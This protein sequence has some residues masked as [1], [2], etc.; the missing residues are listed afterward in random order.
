MVQGPTP[1]HEGLAPA[2]LIYYLL[3]REKMPIPGTHI[4][5]ARML[6]IGRTMHILGL[7]QKRDH[8]PQNVDNH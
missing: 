3:I 4:V 1:A 8:L 2:G 6:P 7:P 5:Y